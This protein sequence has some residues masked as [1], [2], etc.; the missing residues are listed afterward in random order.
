MI[1]IDEDTK[2]ALGMVGCVGCALL[3]PW[4]VLIAAVVVTVYKMVS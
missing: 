2:G 4:S 1:E 3:I